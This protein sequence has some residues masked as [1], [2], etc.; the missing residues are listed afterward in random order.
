[1]VYARLERHMPGSRGNCPSRYGCQPI[2]HDHCRMPWLLSCDSAGS[3]DTACVL[4]RSDIRELPA[5]VTS[6]KR[7]P[8]SSQDG[9]SSFHVAWLVLPPDICPVWHI[10]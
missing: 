9:L 2:V 3:E 4:C 1:M 10:A 6:G 5:G 7:S 8:R